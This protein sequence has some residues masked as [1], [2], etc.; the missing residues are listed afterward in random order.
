M[1][2]TTKQYYT[3]QDVS[4]TLCVPNN[5]DLFYQ[6]KAA[7]PYELFPNDTIKS[8]F[9]YWAKVWHSAIALSEFIVENKE[10]IKDKK[11]LE[12]AA[13][14]GLPSI[15]A[16][17]FAKEIIVSD[18][19]SEALFYVQQTITLHSLQNI[20][21]AIIDWNEVPIDLDCDI[22][23][24]SDVNYEPNEFE[25]LEHLFQSYLQKNTTIMLATPQR[26]MAKKFIEKLMHFC[27]L[28]VEKE[29]N[30]EGEIT[31]VNVLVLKKN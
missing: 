10:Y 18:Y 12:L 7:H 15:V 27:I 24:M 23:M 8:T 14:L 22:L 31:F 2:K 4:I 25:V 19:I 13:G 11:V 17:P 9:P 16:S 28:N 5:H 20:K 1:I 29:I 26:L 21:T 3:F 6:Y 30:I